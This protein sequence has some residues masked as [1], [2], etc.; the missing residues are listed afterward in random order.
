[1]ERFFWLEKT[2]KGRECVRSKDGNKFHTDGKKYASGNRR[3]VC[4]R[5]LCN[6]SVTLIGSKL[7]K[8][9]EHHH[10]EID[11]EKVNLES[12]LYSRIKLQIQ[13][14]NNYTTRLSLVTQIRTK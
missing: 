5:K 7:E 13:I 2:E 10:S 9:G 14:V 3:F 6:V 1:M 8:K 11:L 12:I 4:S